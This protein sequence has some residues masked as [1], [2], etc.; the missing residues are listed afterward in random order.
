MSF[1]YANSASFKIEMAYVSGWYTFNQK[2]KVY[3]YIK[4][5]SL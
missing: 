3:M 2:A 5:P 1:S 4:I